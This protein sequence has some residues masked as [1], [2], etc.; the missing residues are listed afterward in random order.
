MI[1]NIAEQNTTEKK[2]LKLSGCRYISKKEYA[3]VMQPSDIVQMRINNGEWLK[4]RDEVCDYIVRIV[5]FC[6][7]LVLGITV[8]PRMYT[9]LSDDYKYDKC[10]NTSNKYMA[11][12][13]YKKAIEALNDISKIEEKDTT[14]LVLLKASLYTYIDKY[15][16]AIK[17]LE[18]ENSKSADGVVAAKIDEIKLSK[19]IFEY[20][21]NMKV[22]AS[23]DTCKTDDDKLSAC[24]KAIDAK[25]DE[26]KPYL[27]ASDV[28]VK[29]GEFDKA[30]NLLQSGIDECSDKTGRVATNTY[31]VLSN[32]I[33]KTYN[34]MNNREY[35]RLYNELV[36]AYKEEKLEEVILKYKEAKELN[37]RDY[38][39]YAVLAKAYT[40]ENK[41][42]EAVQILNEGMKTLA[43]YKN[44]SK[45]KG[46][47]NY[48]FNLRDK[49]YTIQKYVKSYN[50]YYAKLYKECSK[51][52]S[53]RAY[54]NLEKM[55][56]SNNYVTMSSSARVTYYNSLGKFADIISQGTG[57]AVYKNQYLYYGKWKNGLK[58]GYGYYMACS[59]SDDKV[60]TYIYQGNWAKGF[61]SGK[62]KI[63]YTVKESGEI[64]YQTVTSGT[65]KAG[66]EH[67]KMKITKYDK[68]EYDDDKVVLNYTAKNG[69]PQYL[70]DS[71]GK[72][73]QTSTGDKIIGYYYI[74]KEK[75]EVV[76]TNSKLIWRVQGLIYK[77]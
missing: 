75:K 34:L 32:E 35:N 3:K 30:I 60:I 31:N 5:A 40:R 69:V 44:N 77:K 36:V 54:T 17:L 45:L 67:G 9:H 47:Y 55:L 50:T 61:P 39:L 58:H 6:I 21:N 11:N 20:N 71:K 62:G 27:I 43:V 37:S 48:L 7:A 38:R 8:V 59:E 12:M 52:A 23:T 28:Y 72:V 24:T 16:D 18:R 42:D 49:V 14:Q 57:L 15:D 70:K 33:N 13:E 74:G 64:I 22:L 10:L 56:V 4:K 19:A 68:S 25:P 51:V 26:Y 73:R 65:F 53:S 63:T 29:N 41:Y 2:Y 76:T 1:N 46:K 66:Y